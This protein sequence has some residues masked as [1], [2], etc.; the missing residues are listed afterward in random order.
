MFEPAVILNLFDRVPERV[1]QIEQ[2]AFAAFLFVAGHHGG[3]QRAGTRHERG[4]AGMVMEKGIPGRIKFVEEEVIFGEDLEQIFGKRPWDNSEDEKLKNAA[5]K[6]AE[7]K[8]ETPEN[9]NQ[10]E[11]A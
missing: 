4:E 1:P 7:N 9:E 6:A 11:N 8:S 3:L 2:H 10:P 5:L